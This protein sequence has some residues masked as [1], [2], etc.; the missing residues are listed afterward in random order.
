MKCVDMFNPLGHLGT[1]PRIGIS[2]E[3]NRKVGLVYIGDEK[4]PSY[5][6]IIS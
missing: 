2:N 4:L 3:K 1:A 5:I 6:G